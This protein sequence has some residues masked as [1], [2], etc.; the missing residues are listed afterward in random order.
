M[1]YPSV[2]PAAIVAPAT[3]AE[4]GT[5]LAAPT[6]DTS[7]VKR[8][9]A[10]IGPT[11]LRW[12]GQ[13]TQVTLVR[14]VDS[15]CLAWATT[16]AIPTG[17]VQL[18]FSGPTGHFR[19]RVT[20]L[21][22][23]DGLLLTTS[24]DRIEAVRFRRDPRARAPANVV[25]HLSDSTRSFS[26]P[27]RNLSDRGIAV[28]ISP[29]FDRFEPGARFS[30]VIDWQGAARIEAT[31]EIRHTGEEDG[32]GAVFAGAS[33]SFMTAE[34]RERW[35]ER[36]DSLLHPLTRTTSMFSRDIW[37]L[38][39][40]AG[41][42]S[43]SNKKPEDFTELRDAFR[44]AC[45]YLT[46]HPGVG[47]QVVLPSSRGLETSISAIAE[48]PNTVALYH[49]ARRPGADPRGVEPKAILRAAYERAIRW[50]ARSDRRWLSVW[51]QDVTPFACGVHRD[52]AAAHADGN[53]AG[54]FT[55]HALEIAADEAVTLPF[56]WIV[57]PA[58]PAELPGLLEKF[59]DHFPAPLPSVRAWDVD[60]LAG[61]FGNDHAPRERLPILAFQ[62]GRLVAGALLENMPLG[63]HLF[64]IF[65]TLHAVAFDDT[66]NAIEPLLR[67]ASTWY[68]T[69]GKK[70]F[71]YASEQPASAV[72][73][74]RDLGL[75]HDTFISSEHLGEFLEHVWH[76]TASS[77]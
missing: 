13:T 42:L 44:H 77:T 41:Y 6:A 72:P 26:R 76:L 64:G 22:V 17:S 38:F 57:R 21:G 65:D 23:D 24:P 53:G 34:D 45:G 50:V 43:L 33:L 37:D 46:A 52:F 9:R 20:S 35:N 25:A 55:F 7:L 11:T 3:S 27:V 54:V 58:T 14:A 29:R 74:A 62:D 60:S 12:G 16:G 59:A 1:T 8:L 36:V 30:V 31:V 4:S 19:A 49:M 70:H 51:V 69:R 40:R 56:G 2:R 47:T 67:Y 61:S 18:S 39:E 28:A 66:P 32:E 73:G 75:T 71:V 48:Y 63:M 68:A 10:S 15:R 5:I